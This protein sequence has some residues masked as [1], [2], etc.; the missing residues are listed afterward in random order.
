P[1]RQPALQRET[2]PDAS[3]P[4]HTPDSYLRD[5]DPF[6]AAEYFIE[7]RVPA[8][9]WLP[10]ER[11]GE[12]QRHTRSM[13]AYSLRAGRFLDEV[14][15]AVAA[16]FGSWESLGPG[17]IGGR[18][19]GLVIHPQDSNTMWIGGATGGVWKSADGGQTWK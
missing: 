17:N 8:G 6:E 4:G 5:D 16:T 10:V 14:P 3:V 18:T 2:E 19:R 13:R 9:G 1:L 12:A 15:H 7:Q 11:Y